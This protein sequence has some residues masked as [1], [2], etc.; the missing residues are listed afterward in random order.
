VAVVVIFS[1]LV[2]GS[3]TPAAANLLKIPMHP[4]EPEPWALG[5]RLRDEP[6][7]VHRFT[8]R[9]G[10]PADGRTIA[11]LDELP[12]NAW[13]SF[14]V[15]DRGLLVVRGTT[16]LHEGDQVLLLGDEDCASLLETVFEGADPT[17]L[18]E[19]ST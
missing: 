16:E 11:D 10:A 18:P 12:E 17:T 6:Q 9:R 3:L 19:D 8:V 2:Q 14:I 15:R 1:V 7:G 13:I 5:V 4:I